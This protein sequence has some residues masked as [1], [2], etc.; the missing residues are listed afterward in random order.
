MNLWSK[1]KTV[2]SWMMRF[3]VGDDAKWD[4]ILLPYDI[5]G[6]I[7]HAKGL[8]EI[9]ILSQEE[10]QTAEIALQKLQEK[11]DNGEVMV[12]VEDED[13]HTVIE[14]YLTETCGDLGKKIHTGRSRNDQVLTAIRLYLKDALTHLQLQSTKLNHALIAVAQA[15][16]TVLM[17]G[18]THFQRA[19]PTSV[20]LW[21]A[22]YAELLLADI[23]ALTAAHQQVDKSPLGSAAGYGIPFL[24]LPRQKNAERMGYSALQTHVTATQ[25]SRGK[26]ELHAVHA[27]IQIG[28]TLNRLA[29]D[30]I[31]MNTSEFG[32]VQLPAQYCTGSS[33]MPQKQNPDILEITRASYHRLLAEAQILMSLPANLPSGYHRDLQLTKGAVMTAL[34]VCDDMLTAMLLIIPELSFDTEKLFATLSPDLFATA[35]ALQMVQSGIPFREAYRKAAENWK[36]LPIPSAEAILAQYPTIG[37]LGN[38]DLEGIKAKSSED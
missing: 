4:T 30:L 10:V 5:L 3:T 14:H 6:T 21:L 15:H 19:M 25:L 16:S 27:C 11:Y 23:D 33:I 20:G 1:G 28:A 36:D 31:L 34:Q 29:S 17:A 35:D 7:A 2:D 22:G 32:T 38:L 13:M 12:R 37:T 8:A 26:I 9:G 24:D 18:Y